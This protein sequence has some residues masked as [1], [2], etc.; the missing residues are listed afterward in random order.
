VPDT[1]RRNGLVVRLFTLRGFGFVKESRTGVSF[2]LHCKDV[3]DV[4]FES[5]RE[6]MPVI[7]TA[8]ATDKGPRA[9]DVQVAE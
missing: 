5:L 9:I 6:G 3:L 7:F 1:E 4:P 8:H 2:F